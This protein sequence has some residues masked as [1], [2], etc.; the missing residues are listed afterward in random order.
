MR[1][2]FVAVLF[3]GAITVAAP[4]QTPAQPTPEALTNVY[5]CAT[6][7]DGAQRLAC[8]DAA[9]GRLREAESQGNLIAVDRQQVATLERESFGFRLPTLST[10][11]PRLGD[12]GESTEGLESL[13]MQVAR[14]ASRANGRHAFVMENG[15]IWTQ[16]EAQRTSNVRA[17][18]TI[19]IRRGAIGNYML[20]PSR[21][22]AAHR[23][24]REE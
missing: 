21:G 4:A 22:G 16:A 17:G 18:D 13:Q 15:Q 11:V 5:Q 20:S 10:F 23:V 8:Y 6:V 2:L 9:V 19:T 12:G 7:Q 1:A 14:I 3:T 24:R